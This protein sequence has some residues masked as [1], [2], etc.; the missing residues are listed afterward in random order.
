MARMQSRFKL[1][2]MRQWDLENTIRFLEYAMDFTDM[3]LFVKVNTYLI[4]VSFISPIEVLIEELLK[5]FTQC[6]FLLAI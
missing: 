4:L 1:S 5:S 2:I 6:L 3:T